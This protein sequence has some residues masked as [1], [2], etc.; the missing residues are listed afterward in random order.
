MF[1][2]FISILLIIVTLLTTVM[3]LGGCSTQNNA[4]LSIGQWLMMVDEAFG[5]QSYTSDEPYFS[6]VKSDNPYFA[7]VQIAAEWDVID[8]SQSINT[9]DKLTWEKALVTLVNVG[10]FTKKDLTEDEK[11]EYA[12]SNFDNSIR[13]YWMN[14]IIPAEKATVLLGKAQEK[15]ANLIY[16]ERVEETKYAEGIKDYSQEETKITDYKVTDEG[17]VVI[18]LS[19]GVNI[20]EGD[21]YVLSSNGDVLGTNAYKAQKIINDGTNLY[22]E[23]STEELDLYDIAEEIYVEETYIPTM[24]N[25]VI[26]DGNGNIISIGSNVVPQSN[27]AS[28]YKIQTLEYTENE[29]KVQP[30]KSSVSHTFEIDGWEVGLKYNLDGAFDLE[31]SIETPNILDVEDTSNKE[32]K[33]EASVAVKDLTVTN[34]IDYSWFELK[35]ATLRV[36]YETEASFG[37]KYKDAPYDKVV[38]P[39]YSN[40]NGKFL[41]NLK[42]SV[43]KDRKAKGNGAKTIK[44]GSVDIYSVG[45]ARVCLDINLKI[46]ADGSVSATLTEHG[47]KGL[48]YKNN[49]LRAIKVSDKDIDAEVKAKITGTIGVGPALYTIGLKKPILGVQVSAGLG[50][51]FSYTMHLA[52]SENHLIEETDASDVLPEADGILETL[53]LKADADA[54]KALAES[55]GCVYETETSGDVKL[56][57]DRCVDISVFFILKLELTDTSYAADLLGGKIKVSWEI[58]GEK[59]AKILN[60]HC[61][62]GDWI[63]AFSNIAFFSKANIDQCTLEYKPFDKKDDESSKEEEKNEE[64]K[65]NDSI[66]KGD[67]IILSEIR[68]NLE[69][70]DKYYIIVQ[71]L[72][73]GYKLSDLTCTSNKKSVVEINKDGVAVAKGEGSAIITVSTKDGKYSAFCA[74]TVL[75]E[76]MDSITPLSFYYKYPLKTYYI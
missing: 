57:L 55:Q 30:L 26:R 21:V 17:N 38:A 49:K 59:N 63:S 32:L 56:H 14:R 3:S 9:D 53:D 31:A 37:L 36:D 45:V 24:E 13:K 50:A 54:I 25:T 4:S 67:S 68:A 52:D 69:I 10:N 62:N 73:K 71:Q 60:I 29:A 8:K 41:T 51:S 5:M 28:D 1:K 70:G 48:E 19:T 42:N 40:G 22:I 65:E 20:N 46:S 44:I 33:V 7:A 61:E 74:I 47:S 75:S 16:T 43:L 11:I 58:F 23:N 66:L 6:N 2:R 64:K 39:K 27:T 76:Q 15:W 35:E 72:P 18:P 34:K 12:I